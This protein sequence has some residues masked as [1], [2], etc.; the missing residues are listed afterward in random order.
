MT[1]LLCAS[2]ECKFKPQKKFTSCDE[3]AS[4]GQEQVGSRNDLSFVKGAIEKK[5]QHANLVSWPPRLK[6]KKGHWPSYVKKVVKRA[7][8]FGKK[9]GTTNIRI[10]Q[11]WAQIDKMQKKMCFIFFA[12]PNGFFPNK[13][14]SN[15][16]RRSGSEQ[17][18]HL[19]SQLV[20]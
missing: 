18:V 11:H 5:F 15:S 4:G 19:K 7:E 16:N 20:A 2:L 8:R 13:C 3:L 6:G 17:V 10:D 12:P 1:Q 14:F 9:S